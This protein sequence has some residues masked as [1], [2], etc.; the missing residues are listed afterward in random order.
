MYRIGIDL[1]GTNIAVGIVDGARRIVGA[2]SA[3]TNAQEGPE[4]VLDGITRCVGGVYFLP[5]RR[6]SYIDKCGNRV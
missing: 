3:P 6:L 4:S 1:G 2:A 5:R